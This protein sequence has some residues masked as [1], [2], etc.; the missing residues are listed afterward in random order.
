MTL[1]HCG[2]AECVPFNRKNEIRH[3]KRHHNG[4]PP[5]VWKGS[6]WECP[7]CNK[8]CS[9]SR[10]CRHRCSDLERGSQVVVSS[11]AELNPNQ[12]SQVIVSTAPSAGNTTQL[13]VWIT[14]MDYSGITNLF[15]F[16]DFTIPQPRLGGHTTSAQCP[17]FGEEN[18]A[19][20]QKNLGHG[21]AFSRANKR[22]MHQSVAMM[23]ILKFS[24]R[25]NVRYNKLSSLLSDKG[26][27]PT[28]T[29]N[30]SDK[31][32]G[33]VIFVDYDDDMDCA[34]KLNC[35]STLVREWSITGWRL[36]LF[37]SITEINWS[38]SK[39]NDIKVLDEIAAQAAKAGQLEYSCRPRTCHSYKGQLCTLPGEHTVLK[40]SHSSETRH[41]IDLGSDRHE[42][43][44]CRLPGDLQEVLPPDAGARLY[45]HQQTVSGFQEVGEF[46]VLIATMP[47]SRGLR[48]REPIIESIIH[49]S[50][51]G[52][53][54]CAPF[55]PLTGCEALW[56]DIAP[57]D[58]C[59]L[60]EFA[61]F[62]FTA[63]RSR[64]DWKE[65]FET[66]EVGVR[67]DISVC[68]GTLP[69]F[70]V[71]EITRIQQGCWYS[72]SGSPPYLGFASAFAR[73]LN[74]YFPPPAGE[75]V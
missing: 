32:N 39:V 10:R 38:N 72:T 4:R 33:I 75:A 6:R 11:Q 18:F 9:R 42:E 64:Q 65:H 45:F 48:N 57:L 24:H 67:L 22:R 59:K 50:F 12:I 1:T 71:N 21:F 60:R 35:L 16:K 51:K 15:Y 61:L 63:L 7:K 56:L 29:A 8:E 26:R 36:R 13:L 19:I 73:A 68:L 25:R 44:R 27:S 17:F 69:R 31:D 70:F 46:R 62:V 3:W 52:E 47:S 5:R 20:L 34:D 43:L 28:F 55:F 37:P 40:A 14:A 2:F 66:L 74:S 58:I 53:F 54:E 30:S 23:E 41:V 49:T